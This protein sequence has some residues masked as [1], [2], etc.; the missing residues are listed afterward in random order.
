MITRQNQQIVPIPFDQILDPKTGKTRVRMLDTSTESFA[1]ALALQTR[2]A[3]SDLD[4]PRTAEQLA[5][6]SSLDAAALRARFF[7]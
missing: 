7:G 5:G 2:L 1:S 6:A 4:D 3:A